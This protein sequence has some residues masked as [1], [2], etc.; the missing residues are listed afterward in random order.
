M[1]DKKLKRNTVRLWL[2]RKYTKEQLKEQV[3]KEE[4]NIGLNPVGILVTEKRIHSSP[5]YLA[6][7]LEHDYLIKGDKGIRVNLGGVVIGLALNS[8]YY[9]QVKA[10]G[11]PYI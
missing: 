8:I 2:N 1:K 6:H 11:E 3:L 10:D 9:Y 7:I 4:D 5:I